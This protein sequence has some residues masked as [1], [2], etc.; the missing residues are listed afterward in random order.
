[1][2]VNKNFDVAVVG[3]LNVDILLNQMSGLPEVGEEILAGKMN[4]TLGSSSAIF[5]ANISTLGIRTAFLG[6][7]GNDSFGD[8][9]LSSLQKMQVNTN[10]IL[11]SKSSK[12]GASIALN[13]DNDRAMITFPGAMEELSVSD[14]TDNYLEN[15]N[16]L[17]VSSIFIQPNIKEELVLLFS[18]AKQKGMTT[19]LDVQ[20]DPAEKWEFD[21]ERVL[22]LV[23]VFLPNN[24][25]LM[26]IAHKQNIEEAIEVLKP[27]T[28]TLV[29][30][31]GIDGSL[32]IRKDERITYTP[33]LN[34][35]V[36][37][38]IG[39]GDSFNAGFISAFI[40]GKSLGDCLQ[41]GSICGAVNTTAAGGTGAFTNL[42]AVRETANSKF[43]FDIKHLL[44]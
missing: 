35:H 38:A 36:V 3:E 9:V 10:A 22:P 4:V 19:S 7:I 6:K 41:L 5:A 43:D 1:M 8:T 32:G 14:V 23:D 13:Y 11:F 24:H 33:Y 44:K 28:N 25:E 30:K 16:H 31:M 2:K 26:G 27:Y 12:T 39:A 21:F 18:R 17:H 42:S 40:R 34:K 20:S 37:D 29:V 15:A